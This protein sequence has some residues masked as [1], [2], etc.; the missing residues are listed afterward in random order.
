MHSSAP[1]DSGDTAATK[2]S[3]LIKLGCIQYSE[4]REMLPISK[5]SCIS[6]QERVFVAFRLSVTFVS[7]DEWAEGTAREPDKGNQ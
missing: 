7:S 4:L 2:T 1:I 5:A 6:K 3:N